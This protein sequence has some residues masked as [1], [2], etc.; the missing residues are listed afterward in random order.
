MSYQARLQEDVKAAMR[1]GDTLVRDTLRMLLAALKNKRIELGRDPD[2]KDELQVL[3][4]QK[5][6]REDSMAQ[7]GAA[8]RADLAAREK[9]EIAVIDRYLPAAMSDDDVRALVAGAIA[10]SGAS[11]KADLGKVMKTVMAENQGKVD[12][13][14]VQRIAAELLP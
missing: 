13:K 2:E 5:K 12:G 7:Y 9:A 6:S 1:S 11:S 4:K 14:T 8:G 10:A 3:Q